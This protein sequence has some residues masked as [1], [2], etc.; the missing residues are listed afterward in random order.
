[1]VANVS[2]TI[3][4]DFVSAF[5]DHRP[6][7][8]VLWLS[9]LDA[10][11]CR[12]STTAP[13]GGCGTGV[14]AINSTDLVQFRSAMAI[15]TVSTCN[16]EV[17]DVQD[18][19]PGL[20]P[21]RYV[22]ILEPHNFMLNNNADG[23]LSSG[24]FPATGSVPFKASVGGPSIRHEG[25]YYYAITGGTIVYLCRSK[26]LGATDPWNCTVMVKPTDRGGAH[27]PGDGA[28]APF[29]GFAKDATRKDF[30]VMEK[31]ISAWDWNSNG[32]W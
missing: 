4:T 6:S 28:I 1:M 13:E 18:S 16:T 3:A 9:A 23:D 15:P 19:P 27:G 12:H 20:P 21:H 5:V 2:E 31:N 8:D 17:A 30:P 26:D 10:D 24:W 7:G 22:M 14:L 32:Q 11:R 29:A 25:G